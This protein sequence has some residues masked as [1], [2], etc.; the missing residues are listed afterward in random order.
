MVNVVIFGKSG[1][2]LRALDGDIALFGKTLFSHC[3]SLYPGV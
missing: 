1:M 2:G 3:A